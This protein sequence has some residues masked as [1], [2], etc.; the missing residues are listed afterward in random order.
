M[1]G[2]EAD[3][4]RALALDPYD[5]GARVALAF[6]LNG[7][8]RFEECE[9]HLRAALQA[10]PSNAQVLVVAAAM[11]AW[12]GKP[13]EAAEL[14]DKV[15]LLDP[16]MTAENLNCVKDAYFFARRF[17]DVVAIIARI[18]RGARGRGSQVLDRQGVVEGKSVAE[19]VDRGGG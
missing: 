15:M 10:N 4:K 5:A 8:R 9:V 12:C 3:A 11:L 14:A 6:Y 13:G 19:G 18:P 7:L 16:W 2:M 17:Q 1:R